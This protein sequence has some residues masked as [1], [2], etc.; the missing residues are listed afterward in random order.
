MTEEN[1]RRQDDFLLG[2][3][4]NSVETLAEKVTDL[5]KEVTS[6]KAK[7]NRGAG[8]AVGLLVAS[9]GV[10]AGIATFFHNLSIR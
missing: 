8:F 4:T 3:L 7:M 1:L 10:G 9:G 6:M 5:E 2:Q